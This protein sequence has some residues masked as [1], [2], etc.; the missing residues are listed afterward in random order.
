MHARAQ[1][2]DPRKSGAFYAGLTPTLAGIIPYSVRL[3][4]TFSA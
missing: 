1:W 2:A 4:V 3:H